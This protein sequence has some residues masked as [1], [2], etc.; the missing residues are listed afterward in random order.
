[1]EDFEIEAPIDEVDDDLAELDDEMLSD[2]EN[3]AE[4]A[5]NVDETG[6]TRRET[7]KQSEPMPESDEED[8]PFDDDELLDFDDDAAVGVTDATR[9]DET[10]AAPESSPSASPSEQL[11]QMLAQVRSDPT[12]PL[13]EEICK[14]MV[15]SFEQLMQR[16]SVLESQ[17]AEQERSLES[18]DST[19]ARESDVASNLINES[20]VQA[21][22]ARVKHLTAEVSRMGE[23]IAVLSL[24]R[25]E[26]RQELDEL[27]K[28]ESQNES[29][30]LQ[31]ASL[32]AERDAQ[33][34]QLS[35]LQEEHAHATQ[36]LARQGDECAD[37]RRQLQPLREKV[38]HSEGQAQQSQQQQQ[39]QQLQLQQLQQQLKQ[40]ETE[41][42]R[43]R[44]Q[45]DAL[46]LECLRF[47]AQLDEQDALLAA[48]TSGSPNATFDSKEQSEESFGEATGN[49]PLL[50]MGSSTTKVRFKNDANREFFHLTALANKMN[51]AERFDA[52]LSLFTSTEALY[53]KALHYG[54]DMWS[55]HDW[56][57]KV[58]QQEFDTMFSD[59]NDMQAVALSFFFCFFHFN[60]WILSCVFRPCLQRHLRE[61]STPH[62]GT[63]FIS[64]VSFFFHFQN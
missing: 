4:I 28:A 35:Q 5:E 2:G 55:Y 56:L 62:L 37:L 47:Q 17:L 14:L 63:P 3:A 45:C 7:P 46:T 11:A 27:Q 54:V 19:D 64:L 25:S 15:S 51:F 31:V 44:V 20:E 36:Q 34:R 29:L 40:E 1:M 61:D 38:A 60:I 58:L 57:R 13:A 6:E 10:K 49:H 16:N 41:A 22:Q 52:D 18:R 59:E 39:Q 23:E 26:L 42:T 21:A 48:S 24:E 50:G 33:E 8:L 53:K 43:L 30:R 12:S 9:L 32:Q